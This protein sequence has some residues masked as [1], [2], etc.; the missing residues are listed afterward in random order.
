MFEF[1][2]LLHEEHHVPQV[3]PFGPGPH[4]H[5]P[6]RPARLILHLAKL[7]LPTVPDRFKRRSVCLLVPVMIL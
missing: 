4:R 5:R 1:P 2:L 3:D 6:A 7:S